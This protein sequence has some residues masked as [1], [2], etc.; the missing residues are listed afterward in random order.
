MNDF[1]VRRM[2]SQPSWDVAIYQIFDDL[3]LQIPSP[4][5]LEELIFFPKVGNPDP[6][7]VEFYRI[8]PQAIELDSLLILQ[9]RSNSIIQGIKER[10]LNPME[11][12]LEQKEFCETHNIEY[13]QFK[14]L[15]DLI[16]YIRKILPGVNLDVDLTSKMN[17][18]LAEIISKNIVSDGF[19]H[20]ETHYPDV[21]KLMQ[22]MHL[23]HESHRRRFSEYR[24]ADDL[25]GMLTGEA[26]P[27]SKLL[28][29]LL[30]ECLMM[31]KNNEKLKRQRQKEKNGMT[32]LGFK[33]AKKGKTRKKNKHKNECKINEISV[34]GQIVHFK[35]EDLVMP[36]NDVLAMVEDNKG[37]TISLDFENKHVEVTDYR[38][39]AQCL[40]CNR[41]R[42]CKPSRV[43]T[44]SCDRNECKK[45]E[46]AW[47][48]SLD[49]ER[50]DI[51]IETVSPSG[52]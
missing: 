52:F 19:L 15:N 2:I 11:I 16:E 45:K 10:Q 13:A 35:D 39:L 1:E 32:G 28:S 14:F 36:M 26:T 12:D 48:Q 38:I 5:L 18:A 24:R 21:Y 25:M 47:R 9:G 33:D 44:R 40:F 41:F 6:F 50:K 30:D 42:L 8:R 43:I 7:N 4:V 27:S 34:E 23:T 31:H 17:T 20:L 46:R 37:T 29:A 3:A 22:K 51:D 49:P